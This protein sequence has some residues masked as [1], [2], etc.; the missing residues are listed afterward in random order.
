MATLYQNKLLTE[1]YEAHK[2]YI[3]ASFYARTI[4]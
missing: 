2:G 3:F 4:S 1:I